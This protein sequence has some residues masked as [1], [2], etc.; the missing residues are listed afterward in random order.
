MKKAYF[1]L[2]ASLFFLHTSAQLKLP[3]IIS[4]SMVLQQSSN[5][6]IWGWASAGEKIAVSGSWAKSSPVQTTADKDGKWM[7]KIATPKAGGPYD[8]TIKANQTI[9]LHGILTGEVWICSGQSNM[10]M[11]VEGW[12]ETTPIDN[13]AQEIAAANFPAIRL[14]IA[15]KKVAF[16]PA[17][18]C[19]GKMDIVLTCNGC[20]V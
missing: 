2:V 17:A 8:L 5:A 3:D 12:G 6:P 14:F 11:P 19:K 1:I 20:I 10:E 13:S 15:E 18:K 9:T 16:S 7:V 4:D